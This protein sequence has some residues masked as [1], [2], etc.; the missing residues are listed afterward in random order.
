VFTGIRADNGPSEKLCSKLGL[1]A[2]DFEI[3][4]AIAPDVLGAERVTK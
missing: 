3:L 4:L 2:T 1:R